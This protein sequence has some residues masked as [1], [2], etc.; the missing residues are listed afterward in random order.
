MSEN[1]P[2]KRRRSAL[3]DSPDI[4]E[5]IITGISE[6]IPL[7]VIC[8]EDGMPSVTTV[9]NWEQEDAELSESIARA[10]LIGFDAIAAEA[11]Q[12]ADTPVI[13]EEITDSEDGRTI[14]RADMLGHRKLQV[15][16]RLKLLAKWDPKRYG[17]RPEIMI[18]NNNSNAGGM[19]ELRPEQDEALQRVI[20]D[21]QERVRRIT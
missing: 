10:R 7:A 5:R 15:E 20:Q 19:I 16:T 3:K 18:Q 8:R 4:R 12:I 14:K 2:I 1:L 13:G 11:L 17:D 6:G 9:W 21:A